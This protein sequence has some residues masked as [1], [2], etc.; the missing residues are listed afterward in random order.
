MWFARTLNTQT[1]ER[2]SEW[3]IHSLVKPQIR[4]LVIGTHNPI[5]RTRIS[6]SVAIFIASFHIWCSRLLRSRSR[7]NNTWSGS[8]RWSVYNECWSRPH[9]VIWKM[10]I[11]Y[12]LIAFR[13]WLMFIRRTANCLRRRWTR[14]RERIFNF[15]VPCLHGVAAATTT[16]ASSWCAQ[17]QK[18]KFCQAYLRHSIDCDRSTLACHRIRCYWCWVFVW[19]SVS[20]CNMSEIKPE[21]SRLELEYMN[22]CMQYINI[23]MALILCILLDCSAQLRPV[24]RCSLLFWWLRMTQH[25]HLQNGNEFKFMCFCCSGSKYT[26]FKITT[27]QI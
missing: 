11:V 7:E 5:D 23:S 26:H 24:C 27:C 19:V 9:S 22:K 15:L 8:T 6:F 21:H 25:I 20:V 1:N 10:K 17:Q 2:M 14:V 12:F 16:F 4:R 13:Q 3:T 18:F